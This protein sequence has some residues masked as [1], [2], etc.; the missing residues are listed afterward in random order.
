M[1]W[2]A[3]NREEQQQLANRRPYQQ[4]R[5]QP[6]V[7]DVFELLHDVD[8]VD[9]DESDDE[10]IAYQFNRER[11]APSKV[12]GNSHRPFAVRPSDPGFYP[13]RQPVVAEEDPVISPG[14]FD[15]AVGL[16]KKQRF[17]QMSKSPIQTFKHSMLAKTLRSTLQ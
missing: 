4:H 3:A 12:R 6:S 13:E 14:K 15:T 11:P 17:E 9:E 1:K 5:E 7:D 10:R 2:A 16:S 8:D